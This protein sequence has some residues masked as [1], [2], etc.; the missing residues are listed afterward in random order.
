MFRK[1][2]LAVIDRILENAGVGQVEGDFAALNEEFGAAE[3]NSEGEAVAEA[4]NDVRLSTPSPGPSRYTPSGWASWRDKRSRSANADDGRETVRPNSTLQELST[5]TQETAYKG[6]LENLVNIARA[7][8]HS[9]IFETSGVSVQG[10]A[11]TRALP[12]EMI[13]EAFAA[14]TQERDFKLGAAGELYVFEYLK[15]LDLPNFTVENWKSSIRDRVQVHPEYY[16]LEKD[17]SRS[18]IADI[19]YPDVLR[20]FTQFLVQKGHL[21]KGL[22]DREEPF[23]H[24]EVK[25]TTS[26]NWQEPFFMSK[27]QERHVSFTFF[28][29]SNG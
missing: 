24:I 12:S 14:R 26:P 25:A 1:D 11:S 19:E 13:R 22:W 20:R 2:N 10:A 9:G 23:Y 3:P 18:A 27:A 15:G 6:V 17:N 29:A 16:N 21:A 7:R 4:T 8:V 5:Q 28:R